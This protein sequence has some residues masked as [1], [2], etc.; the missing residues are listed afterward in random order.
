MGRC[1]PA[2]EWKRFLP[3]LFLL[4]ILTATAGIVGCQQSRS[5]DVLLVLREQGRPEQIYWIETAHPGDVLQISWTHSIEKSTWMDTLTVT[6]DGRL[7]LTE[8][9]FRSFGAGMPYDTEGIVT[10]EDGFI[11]LQGLQQHIPAYQ[12]VHSQFV[13]HTVRWNGKIVVQPENIP[14]H[15]GVELVS[16]D[17]YR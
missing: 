3:L 15:R 1:Q 2:R 6:P 17:M 9:R 14:H 7:V 16:Y 5:N 4:L 11:V 8:T 13:Q 12:W 10:Y